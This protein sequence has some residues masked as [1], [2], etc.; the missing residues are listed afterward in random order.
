VFYTRSD[1]VADVA[2]LASEQAPEGWIRR[3]DDGVGEALKADTDDVEVLE[4]GLVG[5]LLIGR[6]V[7]DG[8]CA[9]NE[10]ERPEKHKE[11]D[12]NDHTE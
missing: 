10:R 2:D 6:L 12:I 3:V 7:S 11:A 5:G 1:A 8:E 9:M 4:G